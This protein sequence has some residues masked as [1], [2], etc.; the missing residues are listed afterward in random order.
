MNYAENFKIKH[1]YVQVNHSFGIPM[2]TWKHE[3]V[4]SNDDY[5]VTGRLSDIFSIKS[6]DFGVFKVPLTADLKKTL[7]EV[8]K[9]LRIPKI[10]KILATSKKEKDFYYVLDHD[11]PQKKI[12]NYSRV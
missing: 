5:I 2:Q 1:R 12:C 11:T 10:D 9:I 4:V 8:N 3:I 6:D 7:Y